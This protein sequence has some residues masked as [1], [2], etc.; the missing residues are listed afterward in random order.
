MKLLQ[1]K[2][3]SALKTGAFWYLCIIGATLTDFY[4]AWE[5]PEKGFHGYIL[6]IILVI[7]IIA[8]YTYFEYNIN[9]IIY[10][11]SHVRHELV[12]ACVLFFVSLLCELFVFMFMMHLHW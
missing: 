6:S 4:H 9:K 5:H 11:I 7:G 2:I 3:F 12:E 1:N 8:F 10:G